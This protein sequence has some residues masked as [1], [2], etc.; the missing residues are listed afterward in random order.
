MKKGILSALMLLLFAVTAY[1]QDITVNGTVYSRVDDEPLIGATVMCVINQQ[2][3]ATDIDGSFS[4]T[5]PEGAT[6]KVSYVGYQTVELPAQ[7]SMTIYM[8]EDAGLLDE[9]VVVGYQ[10]VRKADL[11]GAVSVVS[12]KSLETSS[13]SDPMRA[14]QGKIP[15]MTVSANGSPSGAGSVRI[16]G[17]GSFNAS[18]DPL[19]II[20][21]V[22]TTATLNSLNMND[23]ESMQVLK[24]AASASIYGSR[25]AN[26]VIIITTKKGKSAGKVNV[27]FNANFT[28]QFYSSQSKMKLLNTPG[29]ATAMAQAA[30][31]DGIDPVSYASSYGLNLNA[32]S[33]YPISVYNIATG[34][35][36]NY[37][38]NG[39][40]D[41]F[42]N[43]K[44]TMRMSDT[45][46]LDEISQTG[47]A[48]HYDAAGST[49]GERGTALFSLGYKKTDGILK[50]TNF[51]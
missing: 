41:G 14:L 26:G 42:I 40:Y 37:T 48:Q 46:W 31:N 16:R 3:T 4:L 19:F 20:D 32:A 15:G 50:Y 1:S 35:Y 2:G 33:G 9:L 11:T 12:T 51:E 36:Q 22:P 43:R 47:F 8:D 44:Q 13:D 23:I 28:T 7:P 18:Q 27:S 6:I 30:L 49:S 10:T 45:D 25:A 5:V 17:I 29:Y 24:D 38:V 39:Q 34:Q 21:G